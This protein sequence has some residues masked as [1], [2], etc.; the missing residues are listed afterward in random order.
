VNEEAPFDAD[1]EDWAETVR[2]IREARRRSRGYAE[3]WE[4]VPDRSRAELDAARVLHK[5]L[6]AAGEMVSGSLTVLRPDPPDVLLETV[7][8]RRVG[9]EVTEL[10]D[11]DA[12]KRERCFGTLWA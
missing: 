12:V 1:N 9:I 10:L 8:G 4:W 3:Y 11:P 6:V 5:F 7:D 2:S